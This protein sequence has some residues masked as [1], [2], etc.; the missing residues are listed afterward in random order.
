MSGPRD[1]R[2]VRRP[3]RKPRAGSKVDVTEVTDRAKLRESYRRASLATRRPLAKEL[4]ELDHLAA[5]GLDE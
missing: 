4:G 2:A 5:E 3:Q 1:R